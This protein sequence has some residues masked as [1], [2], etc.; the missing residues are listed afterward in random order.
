MK[1]SLR[2]IEKMIALIRDVKNSCYYFP[3]TRGDVFTKRND[4]GDKIDIAKYFSVGSS[5]NHVKF[6][7]YGWIKYL[8]SA[9]K[10]TNNSVIFWT[11]GVLTDET[12]LAYANKLR[13]DIAKYNNDL[14]KKRRLKAKAVV[15]PKVDAQTEL[16]F[17]DNELT[18]D[19]ILLKQVE[20]DRDVLSKSPNSQT[21]DQGSFE[22]AKPVTR[23]NLE[24]NHIQSII[25]VSKA[26][27]ALHQAKAVN[28]LAQAAIIEY[29]KS[30]V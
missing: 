13:N 2:C 18:F 23:E 26:K 27:A 9:D 17:K 15:S 14:K 7:D 12:V 1:K 21:C 20:D 24:L 6:F 4:E 5:V 19:E 25:D 8:N 22:A 3:A 29:D 16:K 30:N 28:Q 11:G 10:K